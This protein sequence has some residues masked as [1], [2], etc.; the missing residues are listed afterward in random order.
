MA[1]SIRWLPL[2]NLA[3]YFVFFYVGLSSL[4]W[5]ITAEILPTEIRDQ[6]IPVA[7]LVSSILWFLVTSKFVDL[8]LTILLLQI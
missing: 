1:D 6:I 5:V 7:I 8:V 3:I 2:L 4:V